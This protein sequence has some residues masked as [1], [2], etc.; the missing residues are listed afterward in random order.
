MKKTLFVLSISYLFFTALLLLASF[1]SSMNASLGKAVYSL[2]FIVTIIGASYIFRSGE[3]LSLSFRFSRT[4]AL[5]ALIFT[6][7]FI[8]L[9][10][11]LSFITSLLLGLI[12]YEVPALDVGENLFLAI[13]FHAVCPAVLEEL[14]F[15]YVPIRALGAESPKMAVIYS[16]ILFSLAH[17]NLYQIPHSFVSGIILA[18]IVVC[19]GSVMPAIVIHFLNNLA[20]ILWQSYSGSAQ[21]S[22]VFISVLLTLALLSAVAAILFRKKI[23]AALA[24][25]LADK[26]KFILTPALAVY[27]VITVALSFL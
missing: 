2:A 4:G 18:L 27:A 13:F 10:F 11:V 9:A 23:R 22:I 8:L 5:A 17:L 12:G 16:A 7:P 6:A 26:T 14:L 19:C 21:F 3:R 1:V 24:P 15:R 20:S 25:A